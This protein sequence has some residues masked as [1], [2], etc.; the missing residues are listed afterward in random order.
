MLFFESGGRLDR[1][2]SPSEARKSVRNRKH[3]LIT[4]R[5]D[6]RERHFR[7]FILELS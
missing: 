5:R 7:L 1:A 4:D 2:N 6:E 3:T